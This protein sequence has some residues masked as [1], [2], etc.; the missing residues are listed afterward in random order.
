[1]EHSK[2]QEIQVCSNEDPGVTNGHN[3]KRHRF[4]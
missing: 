2:D 3:L 1:M 4:I